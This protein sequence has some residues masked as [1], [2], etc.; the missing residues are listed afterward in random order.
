MPSNPPKPLN[1]EPKPDEAGGPDDG[2]DGPKIPGNCGPGL[3]RVGE[4]GL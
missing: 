4:R 2:C 1:K 3:K